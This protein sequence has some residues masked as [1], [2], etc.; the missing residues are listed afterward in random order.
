VLRIALDTVVPA[1]KE[2]S[3]TKYVKHVKVRSERLSRFWGPRRGARRARAAARGLRRAPRRAVPPGGEP[4]ALPG[5]PRRVA[6]YAARPE[7]AAGQQRAVRHQ[8]LQPRAAA[9]RVRPVP[10]VDRPRRAARAARA[11]PARH[12]VL[13]RLVR[14]ELG[15]HR[16]LRR[17]HPVRAHPR[18]RAALPRH[19]AGVGAGDVRRLHGRLGGARRAD[20]LP[21]RVQ[22]RVGGVPRPGGLPRLH[23][24][25]P[26][27][28]RQRLPARQPLEAHAAPGPPRLARAA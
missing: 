2:P 19:R 22:R 15:E 6:D 5:R 12:A 14:R 16:A 9:G 26:L 24:G 11:D 7:P 20:V 17:R 25:R 1:I 23:R 3:D 21:R 8:R 10:L 4:R 18:D 27:R 13:R 28:R